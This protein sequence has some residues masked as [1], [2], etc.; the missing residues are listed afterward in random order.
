M[1]A[2][3]TDPTAHAAA[4][5]I[6]IGWVAVGLLGSLAIAD[7]APRDHNVGRVALLVAA[8]AGWLAVSFALAVRSTINLTVSRL[9]TLSA[10]ALFA[11]AVAHDN[12]VAA[13]AALAVCAA[14][15]VASLTPEWGEWHVSATAYPNER[16]LPLRPPA[17]AQ[18]LLIPLTALVGA[19]GPWPGL[20]RWAQ[21][22]GTGAVLL[23][24]LGLA[25]SVVAVAVLHPHA[26]RWLV[27]VPAGFVVV[28]GLTL[29]DPTLFQRAIVT[30]LG[31]APHD[32]L[33]RADTIDLTNNAVGLALLAEFDRPVELGILSGRDVSAAR[34]SA[35]LF[36][37]TRPGQVVAEAAARRFATRT[38]GAAG[39]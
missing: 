24:V 32:A 36:T 34:A 16:R 26:R 29:A 37:P 31:P 11:I 5:V 9:G 14:C 33:G 1:T 4:T 18:Y 27:F 17:V 7:V 3:R 25:F 2:P 15:C 35:V 28:D 10:M 20:W 38:Q 8:A 23:A 6:R 21:N 19:V 22:G 12:T 39:S 13:S 30:S